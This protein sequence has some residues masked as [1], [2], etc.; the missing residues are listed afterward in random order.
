MAETKVAAIQFKTRLVG[1]ASASLEELFEEEKQNVD[2][3]L[4]FA[5]EAAENGAN[6]I[7]IQV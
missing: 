5:R 3:A 2:A 6:I 7:L 1:G 4:G